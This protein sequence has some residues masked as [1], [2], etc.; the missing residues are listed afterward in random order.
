MTRTSRRTGDTGS[1][2]GL[3]DGQ[4]N[5]QKSAVVTAGMAG[6]SDGTATAMT[7]DLF[8][9]WHSISDH[10]RGEVGGAE[11]WFMFATY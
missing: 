9:S 6:A 3:R 2:G 7:M 10:W 11:D 5:G 1:D 4:P 8:G